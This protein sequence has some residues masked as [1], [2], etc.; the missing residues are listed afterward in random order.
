MTLPGDPIK[1]N[2]PY[3]RNIESPQLWLRPIELN[4]SIDVNGRNP[5]DIVTSNPAVKNRD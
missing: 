2:L 4:E 3:Q 5:R 1:V